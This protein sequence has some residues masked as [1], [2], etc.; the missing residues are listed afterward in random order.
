MPARSA[1]ADGQSDMPVALV[2]VKKKRDYPK[3]MACFS[4]ENF[5]F[6]DHF[7]MNCHEIL[8]IDLTL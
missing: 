8:T 2:V 6:P 3:M 7:R 4:E 1:C 5:N